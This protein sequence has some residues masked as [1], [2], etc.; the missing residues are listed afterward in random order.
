MR[1][2]D[3]GRRLHRPRVIAD[4]M[5]RVLLET[6][7]I[8]LLCCAVLA[9]K[10]PMPSP[11]TP[12][13]KG[14]GGPALGKSTA[15]SA[16]PALQRQ[17]GRQN[18]LQADN[19][20]SDAIVGDEDEDAVNLAAEVATGG[21]DS[22]GL[23]SQLFTLGLVLLLRLG[24]ALYKSMRARGVAIPGAGAVA[25]AKAALY[26]SPIG[27]ALQ[28]VSEVIAKIATFARSP[29]AAPV[30]M[31]LLIFAMKLV[32]RM[33]PPEEDAPAVVQAVVDA[34]EDDEEEALAAA[35]AEEDA[36]EDVEV[37]ELAEDDEPTVEEDEEDE[38]PYD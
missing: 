5:G 7:T 29:N 22:G 32:K 4:K 3:R 33:D 18:I 13:A 23:I 19:Q 26:S 21:G 17:G 35:P 27:P 12:S 16:R 34:D 6:F 30:M 14:S 15:A 11:A 2:S 20:E 36:D 9:E 37:E 8:A 31:V 25:S 24:L 1:A 28:L 10:P 38:D